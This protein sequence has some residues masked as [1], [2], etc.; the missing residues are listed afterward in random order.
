MVG[1]GTIKGEGKQKNRLTG[2]GFNHVIM[3]VC[4]VSEDPRTESS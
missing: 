1:S 3:L 4:G 2:G